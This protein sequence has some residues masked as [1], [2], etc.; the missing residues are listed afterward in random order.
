M[1]GIWL[2]FALGVLALQQCAALPPAMA[3]WALLACVVLLVAALW[4]GRRRLSPRWLAGGAALCALAAGFDWAA[5]R[6]EWRLADELAASW[7]RRD[8]TVTGVIA[9]LPVRSAQGWRFRFDV[10]A[11]E[12]PDA[13]IPRA[14]QLAWYAPRSAT[15]PAALPNLSPG[16]RWR[17]TVR[18]KRPHGNANPHGF[19][20]EAWLLAR[21]VRA[22]GYVRAGKGTA[23]MRLD[24][25]VP[26]P[27]YGLARLRDRLRQRVHRALPSG[28][29][30]A[31]IVAALAIGD[32]QSITPEQWQLFRRTGVN[33]LVAI[34]GLHITLVA[35]LMAG[36]V[37]WLWR[38]SCGSGGQWPLRV[39]AQRIAAL[40]GMS[41]A[42]VYAALAGLGV[43]AQRAA[44]MLVVIALAYWTG[45]Q[46]AV[47]Y[48]LAWALGVVVLADPWAVL[49]PGFWLSF[50]A[51]AVILYASVAQGQRA[52]ARPRW[53]GVRQALRVQAVV[54]LG[55]VPLSVAFFAQVSMVGP[56]ANLL[57]I[58][59][60]GL[61][62]TP[63]ALAGVL[64]PG[65]LGALLLA[66]A[67][68][69]IS[70]LM[71]WLDA[72]AAL[73]MAVWRAAV[74][75]WWLTALALGGLAWLLAPRG[76]PLRWLGA[77]PLLAVVA[78]PYAVPPPGEFR[79]VAL[80]VGQGTAVLVETA[81]H[82]LL[83]DTGPKLSASVDAGERVILPYLYAHGIGGLDMLVIS[84]QDDDHAGGALS[85]LA[86]QHVARTLS[87]LSPNH[88]IV[89]A[90]RAHAACRAG[91]SWV[92]DG[93]RFD[94]LHPDDA[95]LASSTLKPN[96]RSCVLRV[97][98]DRHAMLLP[99]D[100]E[101]A[102]ERALLAR[103]P[104]GAL[105]ADVVLAPHH[106]SLTSSTPAFV[107]AVMPRHVVYQA[108]YLNR[109]G[110]PRDAVMTRYRQAGATA[111]RSDRHGA[112]R[113]DTDGEQ[114]RVE[115]YRVAS[116]RYWMG[117]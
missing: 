56:L 12:P 54:T 8:V 69:V 114:L 17:L 72:L 97:S 52:G 105:A 94:M 95:S 43:P 87:S 117:R 81:R 109:F 110:H 5:W 31:G 22:T 41:A 71:I 44:L 21:G 3:R 98:N 88:P 82:R 32:Q 80:D 34:S 60:V 11:T 50:G 116:K 33:H 13:T 85:V 39:P 91:Q 36:W 18:L 68:A 96:G 70:G 46:G 57:A 92:W 106:G 49:A 42:L 78:Y 111:W 115:A 38:H 40:A 63:L 35:G 14:V 25:F 15:A 45:R 104:D 51:V 10:E 75:P 37:G 79:L 59:L 61:L 28:A 67:H 77:G 16:Q 9:D 86:G 103:L 23:A 102:Q 64:L 65:A 101:K 107:D 76:W 7:E 1:R 113:F 55:L 62:A 19:D 93:V 73:P 6:A 90:S 30:Y 26:A 99:G 84:H 58:P 27:S 4:L 48:V 53:H 89:A 100:I 2:A 66:G 74:P 112:V 20:Y 47:S 24:E 29:P 108:G 83:Y